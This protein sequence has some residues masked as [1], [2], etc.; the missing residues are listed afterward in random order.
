[1][2]VIL[3]TISVSKLKQDQN[4]HT[5]NF[6]VKCDREAKFGTTLIYVARVDHLDIV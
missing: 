4:L 6:F 5:R 2:R 3:Y 1:M